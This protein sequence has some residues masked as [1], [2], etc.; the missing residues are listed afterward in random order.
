MMIWVPVGFTKNTKVA[1]RTQ[2]DCNSSFVLFV[3]FASFV[4]QKTAGSI[5]LSK[6]MAC[7]VLQF[8]LF[9]RPHLDVGADLPLSAD[10]RQHQQPAVINGRSL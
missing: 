5:H 4:I 1:Q 9:K 6:K 2:R 10:R 7:L 8:A 3:R